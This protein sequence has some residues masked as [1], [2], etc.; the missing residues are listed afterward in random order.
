MNNDRQTQT[1]A[2]SVCGAPAWGNSSMCA[3]CSVTNERPTQTAEPTWV[4]KEAKLAK[5]INLI[6]RDVAE[7]ERDPLRDQ[8]PDEMRVTADELQVILED[9][10][11]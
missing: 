2:C 4:A 7:L 8:C 6:I 5:L 10:L 1:A 3:R 9:R 11:S